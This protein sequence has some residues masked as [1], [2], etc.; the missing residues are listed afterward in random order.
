MYARKVDPHQARK[1]AEMLEKDY[2]KAPK[3][4]AKTFT[5][6]LSSGEA[7][8]TSST[9]PKGKATDKHEKANQVFN[10]M[11]LPGSK[12]NK[13]KASALA[14]HAKSQFCLDLIEVS[15]LVL[16]NKNNK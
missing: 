3:A 5:E 12:N 6:A 7:T 15:F 10:I 8:S 16:P 11:N 1:A 14:A 2:D 4:E 9:K 13:N